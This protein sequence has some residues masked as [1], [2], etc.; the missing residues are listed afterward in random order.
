MRRCSA[1]CRVAASAVAEILA[2]QQSLSQL[3]QV[4][5]ASVSVVADS[6][7]WPAPTGLLSLSYTF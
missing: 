5:P 2:D 1:C 6:A 4:K 7:F 3:V